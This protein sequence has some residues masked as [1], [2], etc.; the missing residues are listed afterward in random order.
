MTN[1]PPNQPPNQPPEPSET[2]N[3]LARLVNFIKRPSTLISMG[4]ISTLGVATYGG[5]NYFVYQKLS[6]IL[7]TE[8]SKLLEREVKVGQVESFSL[9]HISLSPS[10]IP[11]NKNDTDYIEVEEIAINFNILP[12]FVGQ[13]I[14][15][16][17]TINDPNLY[18]EQDQ[19]GEWVKLPQIEQ[20]GELNLPFDIKANINLNNVDIA[21]RPYGF[22]K[23]VN[24][25]LEG[26]GGYTYKSN[27][28]Q[29]VNYDIAAN[30]LKSDI[31]IKGETDL[32][33][34]Q[35]QAQLKV[36]QLGI[37]ELA[38]LVPNSPV[39][40]KDGKV[41]GN[42][43]L[44]V[45]SLD[46]IQESQSLGRFEISTI[47]ANIKPLKVP[48][49]VDLNLDFQ[50][51]NI[52]FKDT[53]ISLGNLVT[54]IT[55]AIN[56]Q[57]GYKLDLNL[58]PVSLQNLLKI[59]PLQLPLNL[60][61][62]IQGQ[63]KLNGD[64]T[65]PI[66]TGSISNVNSLFIDQVP[67]KDIKAKFKANLDQFILQKVQIIPTAGG[68]ITAQGKVESNILKSIKKQKSID[69]QKMPLSFSFKS[70]LP[71]E[72]LLTP[73]Y[74]TIQDISL[75]NIN[76]KGSIIGT[77][78][79]PSGK[80]EWRS[81]NL[82]RLSEEQVSGQG[83]I[84]IS[85][86][87]I[88]LQDVVL[89]SRGG[90]ITV[91][92]LGDLKDKKWR[93]IL[94]ANSFSLDPF[95]KVA[96]SLITCPEEVFNQGITLSNANLGLSGKLDSLKAKTIESKG[97]L[98]ITVNGGAIAVNTNLS[99]GNINAAAS[100]SGVALDPYLSKVAVPV[101][102]GQTKVNIFGAIDQLFENSKFNINRLQADGKVQLTVAGSPINA[103]FDL[104]NGILGLGSE[105]SQIS[106]NQIIP[107]LPVNS[108]L[109]SS[110]I[111]LTG[112]LN[113]LINSFS[114]KLDFTTF[115]GT[116]KAQLLLE[117]SKVNVT[118]DL[119]KGVI[120]ALVNLNQLSLNQIA[121][122]LPI[123]TQLIGGKINLS[124]QLTPLISTTP[125]LSSAKANIDLQLATAQGKINTNTQLQGNQWN[126]NIIASNLNLAVIL[127]EI[128]PQIPSIDISSLTSNIS[129]SGSIKDIFVSGTT[130]PIKVNNISVQANGQ[131]L[132]GTGNI[133]L[134]DIFT[135][136][137]ITK[138][139]LSVNANANLDKLPLTQLISLIP[140]D[141]TL[142]PE[143]ISLKGQGQFTGKLIGQNLLTAPTTPG[144]LQLLGDIKLTNFIFNGRTFEPVL[145]GNINAILGKNIAL[146]LQGKQDIIAA[147][148]TPCIQQNCPAPYLPASFELRQIFGQ[149]TP[150][151]ATGKL[152]NNRLRTK[153]ESLPLELAKIAPGQEYGIPGYISGS[154]NSQIEIDPFTLQGQ[155]KITIEK[156]SL[157]FIEAEKLTAEVKYKNDVAFLRNA[158]LRLG[159][160]SYDIEGS[161]NLKSGTLQGNL[162]IE[163]GRVEDILN[164][165]KISNIERLL[166]VIKLQPIDY[167]KSGQVG[168]QSTG[169]G[170]A[171][172]AEQL[173]LLA[174][175]DQKIRQLAD[176]K[177]T[178]AVP[179]ELD[180]RGRFD[181]DIALGGTLFNPTI[182]LVLK[183]KNLE[184]HPQASF[185]DIIEP[186]GLVIR[187]QRFIPINKVQLNA[188]LIN[189][190][191]TVEPA[192]IQIK[193]TLIALD[194]KLSLQKIAAN[195]NVQRLSIDTISSLIE[196]PVDISGEINASGTL[197]GKPFNPQ[198][199]GQFAVVDSAFQGRFLEKTI[200]GQF[201]YRDQRFKL[202]TTDSSF[203]Y[204]SVNMPF[205]IQTNND[206]FEV[207]LKLGK[208]ALELIGVLTQE[209]IVL[210][211]GEGEVLANAE[212]RI[213]LTKGLRLYDLNAQGNINL[214]EIIFKSS[215]FPEPLTITGQINVD[216]QTI[217]IPQLEGTFAKS[218]LTIAGILPLFES[219]SQLENPL[220]VAIQQGQIAL[221]GL[222][223]GQIEGNVVVTGNALKPIIGGQVLLASGQVFIPQTPGSD[224]AEPTAVFEQWSRTRNRR[225]TIKSDN[226]LPFIPKLQDFQV[227]LQGLSIESLPLYQFQFGGDLTINGS[228]NNFMALQPE[229]SIV[230]SR[231]LINFLETRFFMERRYPNQIVFYPDQGILN[232]QLDLA[233]R[234]IVSEVP[235]TTKQIRDADTTE[236]PDDS[237]NKVQRV[238]INLALKGYLTQLI[239]SLGQDESELC[240]IKNPLQPIRTQATWSE[241]ELA[242][243]QNCLTLLADQSQENFDEQL[244]SNP[245][246][247]LTSSPPRSQGQIV[248][249]L[250]E[251]LFVLAEA[252]QGKNT[253]Q[254]IQ[255]GIVQLA[256]PMVFQTL[257]YDMETA[258][259]DTIGSTDFRVVPFLETIYEVED[260][261]FIRLSYDYGF[262]EFRVR[263][264]KRF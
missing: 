55:G 78:G 147:K 208:D 141:R 133:E 162:N 260:K 42:L 204:A 65:N 82:I 50:G 37:P 220:T 76:A 170:N 155:G 240:L 149:Q 139:N 12:A 46:K 175:I 58:K 84:I 6:P 117:N 23:P 192:Q 148:L 264:E 72:K 181:T 228:L 8:L 60:R 74:K 135:V 119:S 172:I 95:L 2:N 216:D 236:I 233:L 238:D 165:L 16:D 239:P 75:G 102:I 143:E 80:L 158:S 121:P 86:T 70:Q 21:V 123:A 246:I 79:K 115:K 242:Q 17:I 136:P 167:A 59:V 54:Q 261:G 163:Q 51:K 73:Y 129:L 126:T 124:S 199:Q 35:T 214:N 48:L 205:P 171:A 98:L 222:Y 30:L 3:L 103:T 154:I 235:N 156:P 179:T 99:Q 18:I 100:I 107:D 232:P 44:A 219:K 211:G 253:E 28:D 71:T 134:S 137:D 5:I 105:I 203:I 247:S 144:N 198:I 63:I 197:E 245:A 230:I 39:T 174:I 14:G 153:I 77:L 81:P 52:Q 210:I 91:N 229:G 10:S 200:A 221:E 157:G 241:E 38:S 92:G 176:K 19:T 110:N 20:T 111:Q 196:L 69:W 62:E 194:G 53:K 191:I 188:N 252:F 263:Y 68:S 9:N 217:K 125:D 257:I 31:S 145:T 256:L 34:W 122:Q 169:D 128:A 94:T 186:L 7:S 201:N 209:Q 138:I 97:N 223:D 140:L 212:G 101:K 85:G 189:G 182:N 206:A 187:D 244:L 234:T 89:T 243:L 127:S 66:L 49:K 259:S 120:S 118:G 226:P 113:S 249:L 164:A 250:G 43:N 47:E 224:Q 255:F 215:A 109:I 202:I 254:L 150:I 104:G 142:V 41:N 33:T 40:V 213:D 131:R 11:A 56:W 258:V 67:I 36:N 116:A 25:E 184:W 61:G 152:E 146:N 193:Q 13:P 45:P 114:K 132:T 180:I 225:Q 227:S 93:S 161:L 159:E 87:N 231:G 207:D 22:K 151:I 248:R 24:L 177:E 237:L 130:I 29:Q 57:K 178:G 83:N 160:S 190:I 173:N 32:K 4:I 262:N 195:W 64:L 112:N 26:Q 106:L 251:Q 1:I 96:C 185:P 27:D 168:I 15:L 88:F 183:G 218:S 166:D 90:D 108:S